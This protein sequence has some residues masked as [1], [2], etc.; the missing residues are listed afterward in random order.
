MPSP[1]ACRSS[2][3]TCTNT[4]TT[5]TTAPRPGRMSTFMGNIDWAAVYKR[6]QGAVHAASASL[7]VGQD[8]LVGASLF[9]VRRVGVFENAETVM[10]EAAWRDPATIER[11]ASDVPTDRA[12]VVYCVFGPEV[13]QA[14]SLRLHARGVKAR[15]LLGGIDAWQAAGRAVEL[16]ERA[17]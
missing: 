15:Y 11:W 9:D 5:W 4:P 2:H 1:V 3:S 12:V 14:V 17:P 13:S 16:K 7:G 8:Q 6:Y 10:P